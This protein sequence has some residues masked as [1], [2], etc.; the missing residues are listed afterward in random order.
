MHEANSFVTLT[1]REE[2]LESWSL[3][4]K[5]F[6]DF[7]KRLRHE[8][9]GARFFMCGEYGGLNH[10]PH[11]HAILFGVSFPDQKLFKEAESGNIYS[12]E[13]LDRIWSH[14]FTSVGAVT[15]ESAQYVAR[16]AQKS[17]VTSETV[18]RKRLGDVYIDSESGEVLQT[19]EFVRMSNGGGRGSDKRGGIGAGWFQKFGA[20]V[21]GSQSEPALDRVVVNGVPAKPPKYYD[22][23]LGRQSEYRL[24]YVK[25]VRE[26]DALRRGDSELTPSRLLQREAVARARLSLK[27]RGL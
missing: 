6:Q 13:S 24:E 10:R 23:L 16:Y 1:Y 12:S 5:D 19:P 18:K 2:D 27:K 15:M 22:I 14:G 11:F 26:L 7:M 20:D 25:F 17:L 8:Y 4:Y 9:A 21:F 3:R